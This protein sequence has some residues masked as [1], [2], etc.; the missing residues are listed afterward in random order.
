MKKKDILWGLGL[1]L[2]IMFLVYPSTHH[3]F[4]EATKSYPYITGFVKVSILAIMGE[5]L[6]IRISNGDF[7]KP[8]GFIL[9]FIVWGFIGMVFVIMFDLFA[10]GVLSLKSKGLLPSLSN[11]SLDN[12]ITAFLTSS[13]M[14]LIFAPT[15]MAFHRVTDTCIDLGTT[16]INKVLDAIDWHGFIS[17]VVIKTIP[18]FWIPAHTFTFMLPA[19]YRVLSASFLSIA[20]GTILALAKK[21]KPKVNKT[22]GS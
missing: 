7:I 22:L 15:F 16:D 3:I 5:L 21:S 6:A 10:S 20:L 1:I 18:L 14:N 13:L 8:K 4:V 17:F 19:E 11:P 2:I 12:F 9:K